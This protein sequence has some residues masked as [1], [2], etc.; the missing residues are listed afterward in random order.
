M[1]QNQMIKAIQVLNQGGVIIFPTDTVW[2]IGASI[3][4]K[5]GI[6]KLY[7]LK[8]RP[9]SKPTAVLVANQ[10]QAE[11]YGKFSNQASQLAKQHWPG[12]LTIITKSTNSVPTSITGN[13]SKVGIRIPAHN[14]VQTI[15]IQLNAG[16]VAASANTAGQP[17]PAKRTEIDSSLINKADLVVG[18]D[19]NIS[20]NQASTVIDTTNNKIKIVRQGSVKI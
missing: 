14:L 8:N 19:L 11:R 1:N 5:P 10:E 18:D 7:Q 2:G 9:F 12:A 3:K 15:S 17:P 16:I 13:T 4:S 20:F 6:T